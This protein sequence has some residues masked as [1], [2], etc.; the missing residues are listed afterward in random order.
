MKPA[1]C[2]SA[3]AVLALGA[4]IAVCLWS[5]AWADTRYFPIPAVSNTRNDG[6]DAG[7]IVPILI[8]KPD[9]DLQYIIAPMFV[10][11]S[12]VGAR[13]A[14]NIFRYDTGG[15]E[16]RVMASYSET[17]ERK[18][19]FSY[20]D[21]AFSNGRDSFSIGAS[22]FKDATMRFFGIGQEAPETDETNYTARETRAHWKF[23]VHLNEVTQIAVGQRFREVEL[24]PGATDLPFTAE[25]FPT[26]DAVQGATILGHRV[27]FLY[28]TR[29]SLVAPTDGTQV[30]AYAELNQNL[31]TG[32]NPLFTD[33]RLK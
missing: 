18:L 13:G 9:G 28:D 25:V 4:A 26:V 24:Q 6:N 14:L 11:N 3:L 32:E 22:F 2:R 7:L 10:V 21:P 31:Q 19:V 23:G 27:T 16:M 12:I 29:D 17:I 5:Q 33:T 8:T 1:H 15:R 20:I 30:T